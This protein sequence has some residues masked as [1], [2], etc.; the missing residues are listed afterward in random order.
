MVTVPATTYPTPPPLNAIPLR[1]E[2]ST[3]LAWPQ[4]PVTVDAVGRKRGP[5]GSNRD[6]RASTATT[7]NPLP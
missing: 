1:S 6:G 3:S 5:A 7:V 4:G 2:V